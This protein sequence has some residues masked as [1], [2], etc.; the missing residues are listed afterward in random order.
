MPKQVDHQ[1]RR[2][3]IAEGVW[4][5][6]AERGL[7]AVSMSTV[8]AEADISIGRIQHYFAGKDELVRF[9]AS[10]LRERIDQRL[11][12]RLAA[13]PAPHTPLETV[14][15]ILTG[16]LPLDPETRI[17]ALVGVAVFIRTLHEPELSEK[18]LASY[19]Q[20]LAMLAEQISELDARA[21]VALTSGLASDLLLG[22]CSPAEA[23]A[24]LDHQLARL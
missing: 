9:A 11:R 12:D 3:Q 13:M 4:R 15:T 20:V 14:R 24:M 6:A 22:H 7:A 1:Q 8:A 18:Y 5:I 23:V 16:L 17:E 2:R 10:H 19:Q 21:L